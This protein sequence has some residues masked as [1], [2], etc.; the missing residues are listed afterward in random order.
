MRER[1]PAFLKI[2]EGCQDDDFDQLTDRLEAEITRLKIRL[3]AIE[4]PR[5]G[6]GILAQIILRSPLQT[7][8]CFSL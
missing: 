1:R 5:A 4:P 3:D 8:G 2:I 7:R 6:P